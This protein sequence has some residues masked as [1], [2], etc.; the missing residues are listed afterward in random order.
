MKP[1]KAKDYLRWQLLWRI[2]IA[3]LLMW[4]LLAP[5]LLMSVQ[6]EM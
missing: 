4:L 6:K 5:W 3:V 2:G 1:A